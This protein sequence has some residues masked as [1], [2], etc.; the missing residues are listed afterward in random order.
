MV[1]LVFLVRKEEALA[2]VKAN[3]QTNMYK[4]IFVSDR[5]I[6]KVILYDFSILWADCG[7]KMKNLTGFRNLS[8]LY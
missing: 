5:K 3:H 7:N 4:H 6:Q 1:S 8:G 2:G